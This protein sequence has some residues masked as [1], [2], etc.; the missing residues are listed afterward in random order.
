[1]A[2]ELTIDLT[3]PAMQDAFNDCDPGETHTVTM[4]ITVS[5][6]GETLVAD[7]DPDSVEKYAEEEEAY[8]E[9]VALPEGEAAPPEAVAI[10]MKGT[11]A[12]E[13]V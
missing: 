12:E 4:D 9:E 3:D 10:V 5:D 1:M 11:D 8:E 13:E 2:N 6:K 7:I